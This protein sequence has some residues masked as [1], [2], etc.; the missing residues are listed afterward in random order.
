M[1]NLGPFP[2]LGN[3]G[4]KIAHIVFHKKENVVFEK[5]EKLNCSACGSGGFRSTGV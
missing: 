2:F 5:V 1:T 4:D 3:V